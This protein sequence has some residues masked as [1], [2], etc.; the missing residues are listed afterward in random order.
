MHR[1]LKPENVFLTRA[2]AT[3]ILD[4]GIAKLAHDE[5]ARDGFSTLTGVVLGTAGY[6]APEQIR[7]TAVDARA[8]LFALGAVLFE[9]LTGTRP[10]AREHI[11][12]TMHAI[13]HDSPPD[14]LAGR[15]D[16]PPALAGVV[17]R[18]LE[19][20][21][22]ARFRSS[23]DLL[24]AL[25]N[26]PSLPAVR[27][28]D[29]H[30]LVDGV[31]VADPSTRGITLAVMP[32][33]TIPAGTGND[34]LE[35]GLADVFISRLSQLPGVRVLPLT[36]TGRARGEDPRRGARQLGANR[37]LV[38]TLQRDSGLVRASVH[39]LAAVDDRT[40]WSTTVDTDASS[41][42]SIQTSL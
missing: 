17:A 30:H 19:K 8:D 39:L 24:A 9:M 15:P 40:L 1:D 22:D 26:V 36:A 3:R 4:F 37:V 42:F 38:V 6:L 29:S 10:F 32:F 25:S 27:A 14:M 28:H 21:P 20:A 34:F 33:R 13:L 31:S 12:E 11:V 23:T 35:V 2:G 7:A 16:V 5:Q 18:L 41:V